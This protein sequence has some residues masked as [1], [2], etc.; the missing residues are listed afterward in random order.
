MQFK[1]LQLKQLET[2]SPFYQGYWILQNL[3][4]VGILYILQ[5]KGTLDWRLSSIKI[6]K[7]L[8][9]TVQSPQ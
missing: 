5:R 2:K 7:K 6:Q 3:I 1:V 4:L 8:E 9:P